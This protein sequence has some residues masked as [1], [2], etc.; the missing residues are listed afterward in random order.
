LE[1]CSI[2]LKVRFGC[3]L[4]WSRSL[5]LRVVA[6]TFLDC[7]Q[8]RLQAFSRWEIVMDKSE[9]GLLERIAR[10]LAAQK[11]SANAHGNAKSAAEAVEQAWPKYLEDAR[12][13]LNVLREPDAR[14]AEVGDADTWSRMVRAALGEDILALKQ[15]RRSWEKVK[16]IYQ[17]PLG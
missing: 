15:E 9:T 5:F 12:E 10:V 2:A 13:V 4:L 3:G 7:N 11:L 14:I 1:A 8:A 16:D 17:K 6:A